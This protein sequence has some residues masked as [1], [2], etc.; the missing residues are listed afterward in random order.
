MMPTWVMLSVSNHGK[1]IMDR[2]AP[3]ASCYQEQQVSKDYANFPKYFHP[4]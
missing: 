4:R 1:T 2:I 3:K